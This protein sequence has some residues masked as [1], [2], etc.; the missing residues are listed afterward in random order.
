M[1]MMT[2]PEGRRRA[3]RKSGGYE[4]DVM[5]T[6]TKMQ[7]TGFSKVSSWFQWDEEKKMTR[8]GGPVVRKREETPSV[9][10]FLSRSWMFFGLNRATGEKLQRPI[11]KWVSA[12]TI[13]QL[14][15]K[16]KS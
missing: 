13:G 7:V 2:I 1:I 12:N 8:K 10:V 6:I 4:E 5:M 14:W 15:H 11:N 9:V 16:R 3:P